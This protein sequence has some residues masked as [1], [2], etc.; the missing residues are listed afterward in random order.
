MEWL[1]AGSAWRHS[2]LHAFVSNFQC[3]AP[4]VV[5]SL[6]YSRDR[7]S[8]RI[9]A[10]NVDAQNILLRGNKWDFNVIASI[11]RRWH[12]RVEHAEAVRNPAFK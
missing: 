1:K 12:L 5:T 11:V 8:H 10:L 3:W 4:V 7:S 6:K 2:I 9:L